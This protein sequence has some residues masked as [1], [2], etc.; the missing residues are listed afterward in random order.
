MNQPSGDVRQEAPRQRSG[1][2]V[3]GDWLLVVGGA[4][5][6]EF[7]PCPP[8]WRPQP[9]RVVA[10]SHRPTAAAVGPLA[11]G[12]AAA[13][14]PLLDREADV[15]QLLGL[16]AEGRSVRLVGQ[17]G[18]GRTALLGAVADAAGELAPDGVVRLTGHRRTSSDLLQ[19]LYA[20]THRS[21]PFRPDQDQLRDLLAP[22]GAVVVIDDVEP[23]G[24]ELEELLAAAPDCAFL[25]SVAPGSPQL[26]PGSRL[27]DHLVGG[28]SRPACLNLV[29]RLA[30]RPLDEH[31]RAWAIDLWFESE[32]LPLRFVQAAALLRQRD[33][34]VD[35]LVAE[36][37]DRGRV[38]GLVKEV[39]RPEDPAE[40][41][42]ELRRSVPLPSVAESAA[43]TL[44]LAAGLSEAA[45]AVLL[46]AVALGGECPTAPHLPALIDVGLGESALQELT[47]CGLAVS[48]GGHHRLT[49][50]VLETL[51]EQWEPGEVAFGA[52]R[53]F[54]WWVGHSSVSPAQLAAEAEVVVGALLADRAAGRPEEVLRLARAAAPAFAL[55]LRWGAWEQVLEIGLEAARE[56]G[57]PTEEA[58]FHQELGVLAACTG[59][60]GPAIGELE[61]ALS[62]RASVEEAR[63]TAAGRR[64][65]ALL[66]AGSGRAIEGAGRPGG[67]RRP[68]MRAIAAQVPL[69]FRKKILRGG[70]RRAAVA[71]G[72]AVLA[73]GVLG[74]AVGLS[75][76]RSDEP[77][78]GGHNGVLDEG[79]YT[80]DV[81]IAPGTTPT[82]SPTATSAAPSPSES[83]SP[84]PSASPSKSGTRKPSSSPSKSSTPTTQQPSQPQPT[85]QPPATSKPPTTPSASSTPPTTPSPSSTPPTSP[86]PSDPTTPGSPSAS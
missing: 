41:E 25:V 33:V 76:A 67:G 57:S 85:T 60:T 16:L 69:R 32:G 40:L 35:T 22:L 83:E 26:P 12:S 34:E 20:A 6:S 84:S 47:D 45:R 48:I 59:V 9:R 82:P 39:A 75:L 19:D 56:L 66:R 62:L 4:D 14:Q 74:T 3:T 36:H 55:S 68:V 17:G 8:E 51:A 78:R 11:L 2:L 1:E 18:S 43:P 44:R 61:A 27:L 79:V 31:E 37:E 24:P 5:G 54:S 52:A 63:G 21:A 28:L 71:A 70:R 42:G 49:D 81:S 15:A 58:W 46:L 73:V 86:S 29:S 72:A 13:D 10:D 50:G 64:M 80:G 23:S 65:L 7:R 53:H 77:G 38:F 30:G